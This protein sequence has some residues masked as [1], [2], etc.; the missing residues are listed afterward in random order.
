MRGPSRCCKPRR[1]TLFDDRN[2]R[3]HRVAH[4]GQVAPRREI[5]DAQQGLCAAAL[6]ARDLPREAGGGKGRRLP[7]PDVVERACDEHALAAA[8]RAHGELFL[9]K[10]AHGIRAGWC[11]R[12]ILRQRVA[13]VTIHAGGTG[14][15]DSRAE[16]E[17]A[18]GL[19]KMFGAHHVHLERR[20]DCLPRLPD[21]GRAREVEDY[22]RT[23]CRD[24]LLH[25]HGIEQFDAAPLDARWLVAEE[26][27][28][29]GA[30]PAL[31][32]GAAGEQ[33]VDQV[34]ARKARGAGDETRDR[35]AQPSAVPYCAS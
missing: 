11:E 21:V 16:R 35:S 25:R 32:R 30:C 31:D 3:L 13:G 2:V 28:R 1:D 10:L 19:E 7:R 4:I 12:G 5:A 22:R 29:V 33:R 18:V 9:R 17:H 27:R 34:A 8:R 26:R 6:D 23:E 15:E 24:G 14:H 20:G